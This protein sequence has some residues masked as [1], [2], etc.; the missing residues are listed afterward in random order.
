MGRIAWIVDEAFESRWQPNTAFFGFF[1]SVNDQDVAGALI[2]RVDYAMRA[3]GKQRMLGPINLTLHDEV[4]LLVDGFD[5]RPMVMSPCNPPY[6][7]A[8]IRNA[9]F[10]PRHDYHS[11]TWDVARAHTPAVDRLLRSAAARTQDDGVTIRHADRRRWAQESQLMFAL[12]NSSF[13]DVWGFVPLRPEE[14]EKRAA[15]IRPFYNPKLVLFA[16]LA[17]QTVG[18]ALV[19]PDINE[20][21]AGLNGNLWP[22][23]WLR[24]ALGMRRVKAARLMLLGVLPEYSG[25]GIAPLI[26][27]EV[28]ATARRLGINSWELSLVHDSNNEC[29]HLVDAFGGRRIKTYR[30]YEK[31]LTVAAD[32]NIGLRDRN[33]SAASKE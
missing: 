29:N 5:S 26:A 24:L 17:G 31:V 6:Y 4:G 22:L 7:D 28:G 27:H 8:L 33:E 12:Y 2:A 11:L 3:E 16:E 10:S 23:G 19:L 18:F 32:S 25:R 21:L 1:E 20:V 15:D 13:R 14:F 9:G 30:L